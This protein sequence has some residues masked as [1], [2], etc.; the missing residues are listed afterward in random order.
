MPPPD[1]ERISGI[2]IPGMPNAHSHAFQSAMAGAAEYRVSAG[3]SFWT[4]RD[5]MYRLANRLDPAQLQIIGKDQ[6][7][8]Y[9]RRRGMDL[10]EAE[11][12]L[13][14]NLSYEP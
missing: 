3:D 2:V 7:T 8:D 13:R 9:A 14:P 12:W 1:A 5:A 11:R 6:V 4:W 10:S